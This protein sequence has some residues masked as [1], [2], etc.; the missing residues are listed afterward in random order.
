MYFEQERNDDVPVKVLVSVS[1][2]SIRS[3]VKRNLV[4]RQIREVYRKN[5]QILTDVY[6]QKP[7]KQLLIAIIYTGKTIMSSAEVD[8]KLIIILHGLTKTDG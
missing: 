5:K 7:D 4:K 8:R 3:A 2:R 1:K 6:S